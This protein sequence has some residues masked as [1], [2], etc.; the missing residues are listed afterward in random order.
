MKTVSTVQYSMYA[1]LITERCLFLLYVH[2]STV[3]YYFEC[4][5]GHDSHKGS[6]ESD[7][8]PDVPH[9]DL[10]YTVQT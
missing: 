1:F 2:M 7:D 5:W 3:F 10:L 8:I 4:Y 9:L 6:S